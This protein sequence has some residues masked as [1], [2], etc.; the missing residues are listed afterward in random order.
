MERR[1]GR[2]REELGGSWGGSASQRVCAA[3]G[4]AQKRLRPKLRGYGAARPLEHLGGGSGRSS[5]QKGLCSPERES[6]STG[7]GAQGAMDTAQ[8]PALPWA[9]AEARRAQDSKDTPAPS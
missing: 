7:L 4:A 6:D 5:T 3:P 1:D 9:Q 2:P 8:D